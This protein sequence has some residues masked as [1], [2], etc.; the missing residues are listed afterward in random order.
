MAHGRASVRLVG[1]TNGDALPPQAERIC[2]DPRIP[3]NVLA[4]ALLKTFCVAATAGLLSS[5]VPQAS[6]GTETASQTKVHLRV[7]YFGRPETS[8]SKDFVAF[9]EKHFDSVRQGELD[10]FK[11]EDA[12][13]FDVVLLDYDE[14]RLANGAIHL[15]KLPI[16]RRYTRPTVTIGATGA[17]ISGRLGLKTGYL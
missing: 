15:P 10:K 17:L 6:A 11:Q 7:G 12:D 16:Y 5:V 8:R 2:R 4:V 9:L 1:K 13:R 14:V 3:G